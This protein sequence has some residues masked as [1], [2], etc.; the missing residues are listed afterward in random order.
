MQQWKTTGGQIVYRLLGG[1]V[2]VFLIEHNGRFLLID[3]AMKRRRKKLIRALTKQGVTSENLKALILTHT[4]FDHAQN[5]AAVIDIFHTHLIVHESEAAYLATGDS[6][7]PKGTTWPAKLLMKYM[8]NF[9]RWI[10]RYAPAANVISISTAFDLAPLGFDAKIIHTPG[11]SKGSVTIILENE[12]ALTGDSMYGQLPGNV[13]PAFADDAKL[14]VQNWKTVMD[15]GC[16]IF[17]P[18]HGRAISRKLL[19]RELL[20]HLQFVVKMKTALITRRPRSDQK[21][22]MW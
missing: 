8:G 9:I 4:H 13:F 10:N 11:H 2:N 14:M 5:A 21:Y 22:L 3:T 17:L 7:L 1:R 6:P 15:T 19:A 12:I 18:A 16:S 20:K